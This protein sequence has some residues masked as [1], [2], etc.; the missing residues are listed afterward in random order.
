ML[1]QVHLGKPRL[2][3]KLYWERTGRSSRTV[4]GL[5]QEYMEF[6]A[7]SIF[8]LSAYGCLIAGQSRLAEKCISKLRSLRDKLTIALTL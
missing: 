7:V 4:A 3:K 2:G 8:I 6:D 5:S 1:Q